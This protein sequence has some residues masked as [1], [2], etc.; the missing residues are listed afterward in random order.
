MLTM[1]TEKIILNGIEYQVSST[2]YRG[3]QSAKQSLIDSITK[4]EKD[5]PSA[6]LPEK[7]KEISLTQAESNA[8][9]EVK[10][11]TQ[12]KKAKSTSTQQVKGTKTKAGDNKQI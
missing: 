8:Q 1:I 7:V 11:K 10:P 6:P 2:T 9:A 12:A 5:H 4:F 3:L